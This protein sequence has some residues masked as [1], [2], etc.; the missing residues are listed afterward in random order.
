MP[1]VNSLRS[2]GA[3]CSTTLTFEPH[4]PWPYGSSTVAAGH[5]ESS[6]SGVCHPGCSVSATL[7][8]G[9]VTIS[10]WPSGRS[11]TSRNSKPAGPGERFV[12]RA[13]STT[14]FAVTRRVTSARWPIFHTSV[15]SG[16]F[17]ASD[18][19][20]Y[21]VKSSSAVATSRARTASDGRSSRVRN[22]RLSG[23]VVADQIH[24]APVKPSDVSGAPIHRACQGVPSSAVSHQPFALHPDTRFE[25]S[26]TRTRQW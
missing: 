12:A 6:K 16:T 2:N 26:H 21:N 18:P 10:R 19:L 20:T 24:D 15:C 13:A 5:A 8:P 3:G 25:P 23:G 9:P 14:R 4:G 11:T 1:S 22:Q 7:H 17:S